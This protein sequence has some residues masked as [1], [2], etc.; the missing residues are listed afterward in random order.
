LETIARCIFCLS[1][2]ARFG[3]VEHIVPESLGNFSDRHLLAKG[4]VCDPCNNYFSSSVEAPVL[5]HVSFQ[6]LRAKY[7]IPT[8]RGRMPF[9]RGYAYGTDIEVGV[10]VNASTKKVE[11]V[12]LRDGQRRQFERLERLDAFSIRRNVFVFPMDVR[13]PQREMSR[14]LAKMAFEAMFA[15]SSLVL[16]PGSAMDLLSTEHYDN[17]RNWARYGNN[18][19]EWPFHYRAYFPEETLMEHPET[20]KWVQF[21]FGYDLLLTDDPETYF[22]FSCHGHEFSINLGG[23]SIKGYELWLAANGNVSAL[24]EKKGFFVQTLTE[25]GK[26]KHLLVPILSF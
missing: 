22:V 23:P 9:L 6:N 5:N 3:S 20:K 2:N 10:R 16:G 17:I 1:S 24:V 21:G 19:K 26:H 7:Q 14:F 11:I 13:P 25:N 8:K 4:V 15:R 18:F 12:P